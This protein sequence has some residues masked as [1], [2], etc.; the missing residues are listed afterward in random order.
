MPLLNLDVQDIV[1]TQNDQLWVATLGGVHQLIDGRFEHRPIRDEVVA[2]TSL[3]V[4]RSNRLWVGTE[5]GLYVYNGLVFHR[6][7]GIPAEPIVDLYLDHRGRVWSL[8][9]QALYRTTTPTQFELVQIDHELID[10]LNSLVVMPD[11]RVVIGS[12]QNGLLVIHANGLTTNLTR[13]DGLIDDRVNDLGLTD[14]FDV[15][16]YSGG[17][18]LMLGPSTR[19]R[20]R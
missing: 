10:G 7:D 3:V 8:T 16:R 4:D 5:D 17:I 15:H 14:T 9:N 1:V 12:N 2:T 19:F 11:E 13:D 18:S 20:N 6:A